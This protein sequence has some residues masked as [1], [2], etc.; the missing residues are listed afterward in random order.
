MK[1][2]QMQRERKSFKI[3]T[4]FQWSQ[5]IPIFP[6]TFHFSTV[7]RHLTAHLFCFM[8]YLFTYECVSASIFQ[9]IPHAMLN[10]SHLLMLPAID[11]NLGKL[12]VRKCLY[13]RGGKLQSTTFFVDDG[14]KML[15][16]SMPCWHRWFVELYLTQ[17]PL[18]ISL[19]AYGHIYITL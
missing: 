11:W 17:P 7:S 12:I 1:N 16:H 9:C 10:I 4:A 2:A 13:V 8:P 3:C 15:F 18:T 19:D 5:Q 6:F 14:R